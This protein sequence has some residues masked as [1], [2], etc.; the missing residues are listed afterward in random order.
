VERHPA[1]CNVIA[2]RL[3]W[4]PSYP[5]YDRNPLLLCKEARERGAGSEEEI[6]SYVVEKLKSGELH[7]AAEDPNAPEN[8]PRVMFFWRANVLGVSNRGNEYFLRH[9]LGADDAVLDQEN[10]GFRP[11]E[12]KIREP[13]PE[14]KLDLLVTLEM[15]MS[16]SALY[17]DVILPA[18]TWYEFDDLNT[19]DLHPF[20]HPFTPAV[21]P[22]FESKTNWDQ[23]NTIAQKFSELAA[24][25]LGTQEDLVARPLH[26]DTPAEMAQP[27]GRV[28]DWKKGE[29]EPVPGRT[30]PHFKLVKRDFPNAFKMITALGPRVRKDGVEGK[31]ISWDTAEEYEELKELLMA[32]PPSKHQLATRPKSLITGDNLELQWGPNWEDDL[33]GAHVH[34]LEDKNFE[35]LDREV[36]LNFKNVFMF[37]LPRICEHCLNPACLASCPAG[38]IY[39]RDE[40]GIVL[41]DQD[42]CRGWR[43]CV[44]GCP[45][46][47]AYFNWESHK[48]EKCIFCY[49]RIEAGLPT[50]C[51]ESC[52]GRI[53][54]IGIILYDADRLGD[55][56]TVESDR[57]LYAAQ[58]SLFLNPHDPEV[59]AEAVRCGIPDGFIEAARR[60]PVYKLIDWKLALPP[61][62]E[63][64][65]LPMAWYIP[66]LSPILLARE[67]EHGVDDVERLRI[68]LRY[69]AN[70]LAAGDEGPVRLAL[71]RLLALRRYMRS[72]H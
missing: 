71:E 45:Y 29:V 64:R 41:I 2:A 42:K 14:G 12:M 26:H 20:I 38:A 36:Y 63:F 37:W 72:I 52:V 57:E 60:S 16:T 1:D 67:E 4:L 33:A 8:I 48:S 39:K 61:H 31:G 24:R 55:A 49:P 62:P 5:Q 27:F 19:T 22:L 13:N 25:H 30:M 9:L 3:G 69:L 50:L 43:F 32:S 66:P 15:R 17:S 11:Q 58:T 10:L 23:F 28:K 54:F 51:A 65:T 70:L 40:D 56:A 18:A 68:P 46:K 21:D 47:K 6:L 7:F 53:R 35:G 34:A 59:A 44:S